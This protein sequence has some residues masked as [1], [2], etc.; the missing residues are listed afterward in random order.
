MKRYT[1][2]LTLLFALVNTGCEDAK[3]ESIDNSD[4]ITQLQKEITELKS[5]VDTLFAS[6]PKVFFFEGQIASDGTFKVE[7]PS[8][9]PN[10]LPLIHYQFEFRQQT[11]NNGAAF[12]G[13]Y[14]TGIGAG[15]L[16]QGIQVH[17]GYLIIKNIWQGNPIPNYVG[18]KVKIQL[19]TLN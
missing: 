8:I 10:N 14:P 17:D 5:R 4:E 7:H 6:R 3:A 16:F 11:L 1:I 19:T 2:G 15:H 13:L 9:K 12:W 18:A